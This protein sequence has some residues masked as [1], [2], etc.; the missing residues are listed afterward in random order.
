MLVSFSVTNF[1]SFDTEETLSLVASGR[2]SGSHEEHALPIPNSGEKVLR[3]AVLYG[4]NGAGKSNLFKALRYVKTMAL[5]PRAGTSGT[6][7][8]RFRFADGNERPSCFELQIVADSKLYQYGFKADDERITEEWLIQLT[9]AK[10][11]AVYERITDE[12]GNVTIDISGVRDASPKLA[13]LATVGGPQNQSFLA[14]ANATI[15]AADAGPDIKAVLSW[16]RDSLHL[17]GPDEP[18][19]PLAH[20]L[21]RDPQ[22][23]IFA[24]EFLKSASTGID[25]LDV[26]KEELSEDQM[27]RLLPGKLVSKIL[28]DAKDS[29]TATAIVILPDG[30][31]LV[32]QG[33][34][35]DRLQRI[36]I[37]AAHHQG[38]G[39]AVRLDL[40]EESDGTQ[41]LLNLIP[42]L[43]YLR[44]SAAVFF[45]DEIDRSL[46]PI[47][48]RKFLEFFLQS[49]AGGQR[50]V[51][52]TTHE[53]SLLDQEL[54]RRDEIWFA[55]KDDSAATHLY[56]LADFKVRKD[57][58]L[59]RHYLQGR[60]G[61]VP[62]VG[63]LDRLLAPANNC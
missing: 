43:H 62:F 37:K 36:Q 35:S 54:L 40:D 58:E 34:G 48:V 59:R 8:Q 33:Q 31:D 11:R 24:G 53:S 30:S 57:L 45:V 61:A 22:F 29:D 39:S 44:T 46:H 14:T 21:N 47:L 4:A 63:G 50:Q 26:E 1:R 25:H 51:I 12:T 60:F 27:R 52:V 38:S 28:A 16:F 7:R 18:F 17:I 20:E 42:A 19:G 55:E 49:C 2:L 13:A 23:R 41:R 32:V 5:Q 9:R 10:R 56:S 3:S 6:G 15:K